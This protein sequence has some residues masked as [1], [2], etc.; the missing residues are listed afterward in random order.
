MRKLIISAALATVALAAAAGCADNS[1]KPSSSASASAGTTTSAADQTAAVCEQAGTVSTTA[2]EAIS[3]KATEAA[4][5][6]GDQAK[7]LQIAG[8][9]IKLANDWSAKLTELSNKPIKPEVKQSLTEG[10]TT[11]T[12]LANPAAI[13]TTSAAQVETKLKTVVAKIATA[14]AAS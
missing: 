14:C 13:Q 3:A 12:G 9:L 7:Q 4:A 11:I 8:D 1:V 6:S 5:A 2:G 10:A